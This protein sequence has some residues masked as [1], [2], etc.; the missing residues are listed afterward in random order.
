MNRPKVLVD[1]SA[2][3]LH[4]GHVRLLERACDLG[5]V[6]VALSSDMEIL[7]HKGYKP[8]LNFDQRR[9]ILLSIKFV[10]D[11]IESPWVINDAF[12]EKYKMDFLVH[13]D[14]NANLV[15][16]H[17]LVVLPRTAGISSSRI[18]ELAV[19]AFLE[20]H[21]STGGFQDAT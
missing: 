19:S 10:D 12:M 18:R 7:K 15:S 5:S 21:S 20:R 11:V 6:T 13:G 14:D 9:E 16:D 8:E 1:M 3:L 17:Y 2:T 4:H